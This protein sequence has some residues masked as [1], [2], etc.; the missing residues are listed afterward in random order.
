MKTIAITILLL[1]AGCAI[2]APPSV[3]DPF[4]GA[5]QSVD[6]SVSLEVV[7]GQRQL[8]VTNTGQNQTFTVWNC[9]EHEGWNWRQAGVE[10]GISVQGHDDAIRLVAHL[11]NDELTVTLG[12]KHWRLK[13]K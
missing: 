10:N 3:S 9:L 2:T 6:P 4:M 7:F 1:L 12:E 8:I 11:N 13:R 5:W